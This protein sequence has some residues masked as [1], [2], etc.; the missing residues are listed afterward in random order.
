MVE[1]SILSR[2]L[3]Y[4][5]INFEGLVLSL[6]FLVLPVG[7]KVLVWS[8]ILNVILFLYKR[9]W[10]N[11]Y[12][13][14][15]FSN[16][17]FYL[18]LFYAI[19]IIG[20]IWTRNF[21][22]ANFELVQKLTFLICPIV[23]YS[24]R[25]ELNQH[26]RITLYL[27]LIGI[28]SMLLYCFI[29]GFYTVWIAHTVL[30]HP[31]GY[32][33]YYNEFCT[34]IH[35][36]YFSL[37]VSLA[38]FIALLEFE[39]SSHLKTRFLWIFLILFFFSGIYYLSSKGA[40]LALALTAIVYLIRLFFI[41]KQF[42][43][44]LIGGSVIAG[45]LLFLTLKN[46][47]RLLYFKEIWVE[48]K[49][50]DKINPEYSSDQNNGQRIYSLLSSIDIWKAHPYFG[51]G[52][53]DALDSLYFTY[54][55][56]NLVEL[57]KKKLNSHNQFAST[58]IQFG[59]LGLFSLLSLFFALFYESV[60]HRQFLICAFA[61]LCFINMLFESMLCAQAGILFFA[62]WYSWFHS[63]TKQDSN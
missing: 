32:F 27:F 5:R 57:E 4:A 21:D 50:P 6:P 39:K 7:G 9:K 48:L 29:N 61:L 44:V 45:M 18:V 10:V 3:T 59:L 49:H 46:N 2:S 47:P 33:P 19:H 17:L 23:Y 55:K 13:F 58:A 12:D 63:V 56:R 52:T 1:S 40:W 25:N 37:Y 11:C 30:L 24:F 60:K 16:R 62:L 15:T 51:V 43:F 53:G 28:F 54:H 41:K 34:A 35:V 38:I 26:K 36:S 20:L 14:F 22:N 8:I 31:G 42:R